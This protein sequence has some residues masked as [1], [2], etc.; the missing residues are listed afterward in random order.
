MGADQEFAISTT[1]L[2]YFNSSFGAPT[3]LTANL[4]WPIYPVGALGGRIRCELGS[5]VY[6]MGAV[7]DGDSGSEEFNRTGFRVRLTHSDGLFSIGGIGWITGGE[8]PGLI[9][10]GGFYHSA[11]FVKLST[12]KPDAGF[13]GAYTVF[14]RKIY[15]EVFIP[16]ELDVHA[17]VGVAQQDRAFINLGVDASANFTGLL[18]VRPADVLGVGWIYARVGRDFALAQPNPGPWSY[19]SIIEVT[20]K[21][22]VTPALNFQPDFQHIFHPGRTSATSNATVIGVRV[23]I[24]F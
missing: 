10:L 14:Q 6:L 24:K 2:L 23:D 9:K 4:A 13:G 21:F 19:E 15:K 1:G 5:G 20:Y 7:Y 11:D 17:R 16:G 22:V 18:P 3:F 12:G 8:H